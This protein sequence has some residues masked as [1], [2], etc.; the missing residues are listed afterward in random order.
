MKILSIGTDRKIFEDSSAVRIRSLEYSKIFDELHIIVFSTQK[1]KILNLKFK[2]AENVWVYPTNS[3]SKLFY[4]FDAFRIGR[5]IKSK[6]GS[7]DL[8]ISTQDPFETGLTGLLLKLFYKLPLQVQVHVDFTNKYFVTH[9]IL[10]IIRFPLGLFILSFADSVRVVSERIKNSIGMLGHN[11]EIIPI[12][13]NEADKVI[14]SEKP[15]NN[16]VIKILTVCRLEK[17]KDIKTA[18]LAFKEL[19]DS[20]IDAIF[21]IVGDGRE[22]ANLELLV[23][24]LGLDKRVKFAGWHQ[25]LSLFFREA[26]IYI[27][28]SL[29]EGYGMSVVEAASFGLPLV[30]SDAGVAGYTFKEG[31]E[32]FVVKPKSAHSFAEALRKLSLES[33]LR[34]KM[35]EKARASAEKLQTT[36]DKYLQMYLASMKSALDFNKSGK[37]IFQRNMLLRYFV[38][39]ITAA[40]T[41]IG[42]L[43]VFTD[44]FGVWYLY[45]SVVAFL[46]ALSLSF[47]LQKFWTFAD[48][49]TS[50][51]HHQ[52]FKYAITAI[53]GL[54]FN[55]VLMFI[56]VDALKVWYIL[57]QIISGF[58]VMLFN[59][60][61]YKFFIFH[62]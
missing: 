22:K 31:E 10:N 7:A 2:I 24:K 62:R 16:G 46:L 18:I 47:T 14:F 39:G 60:I 51:I 45:S 13:T 43:F 40:S 53:L 57:A 8:V 20:G 5:K 28:T 23:T 37:N 61:A 9:S 15:E 21:T 59:F 11:V 12:K 49:E 52:F 56:L 26:D 54:S 27:S 25:D 41:N 50:K 55:T 6:L 29:Y 32:A 30:L 17:E 44:I 1:F 42:L 33:G 34:K 36:Q 35:G 3:K 58:F 38:A 48:K 19:L 4:F